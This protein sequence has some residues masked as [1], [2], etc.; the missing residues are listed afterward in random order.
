MSSLFV[1]CCVA[2][3][4][5]CEFNGMSTCRFRELG[6]VS[7]PEVAFDS[8]SGCALFLVSMM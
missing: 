5:R 3:G 6:I 2:C 4:L 1:G 8:L 7:D